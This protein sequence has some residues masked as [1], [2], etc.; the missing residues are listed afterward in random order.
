MKVKDSLRLKK[1]EIKFQSHHS[2]SVSD[3]VETLP[4]FFL[5]VIDQVHTGLGS[6][7][8]GWVRFVLILEELDLGFCMF[9]TMV[10]CPV[11]HQLAVMPQLS[12]QLHFWKPIIFVKIVLQG[13][14]HSITTKCKKGIIHKFE[15]NVFW[16]SNAMSGFRTIQMHRPIV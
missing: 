12:H 4:T 15:L 11:L 5:E 1:H 6:D 16:L 7:G 2:G 14:S 8:W 13:I 10:M 3:T 9:L